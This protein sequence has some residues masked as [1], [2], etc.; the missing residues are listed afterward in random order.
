[1]ADNLD[2]VIPLGTGSKFRDA[3]LV[4]ALRSIERH[5]IGYRRVVVVGERPG[6]L[7]KSRFC[8]CV[9]HGDVEGNKEYRIAAKF[10]WAFEN[11]SDL[12]PDIVMWNDDYVLMRKTDVRTVK[13]EHKGSL[14]EAAAVHSSARYGSALSLTA[15]TL[16]KAGLRSLHYDIHQ[17]I[18]YNREKF[19]TLKDFWDISRDSFSG[20]V[21]KSIYANNALKDADPGKEVKD[22]KLN[23][24]INP[25]RLKR[26]VGNRWMFSYSDRALQRGL[27]AWL[28][29]EYPKPSKF[30]KRHGNSLK[31]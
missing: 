29:R 27:L 31:C 28:K 21:V 12:T 16:E 17:P 4:F 14:E 30:E 26:R 24:F 3:E 9:R 13:P 11:I 10:A 1:M 6:F 25:A 5:A 23:S 20:M 15:Q 8:E 22:L 18:I 19:L 7:Y 2:I